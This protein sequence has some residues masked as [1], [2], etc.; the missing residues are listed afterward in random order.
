MFTLCGPEEL[1]LVD[2][3]GNDAAD[4]VGASLTAQTNGGL[5]FGTLVSELGVAV[6]SAD[7]VPVGVT[8]MMALAKGAQCVVVITAPDVTVTP[9]F[10][11]LLAGISATSDP[12]TAAAV[13]S[14][15]DSWVVAFN[16]QL[17]S[18][19]ISSKVAMVDFYAELNKWVSNPPDPAYGLTNATTPACPRVGTDGQGLPTYNIGACTDTLLNTAPFPAGETAINWWQTYV[20]SD[21]FHGTPRTNQLMGELVTRTLEARGWK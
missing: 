14:V 6:P 1:L 21:N 7:L 17:K 11:T 2:G 15:A 4:L 3:G 5:S 13:T 8:C 18:R 12:A 20:F 16:T 19:S 10:L 9:R